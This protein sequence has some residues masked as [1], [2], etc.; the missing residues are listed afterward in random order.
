VAPAKPRTYSDAV[1]SWERWYDGIQKRDDI[2][3]GALDMLLRDMGRTHIPDEPTE[4]ELEVL[5]E[6]SFGATHEMAAKRMI[7]GKE[8]IKSHLRQIRGKLDANTSTHAVAI[9]LRRGLIE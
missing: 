7:L 4:R 6:L 8:T 9:A 1:Q 3:I 5:A 2:A